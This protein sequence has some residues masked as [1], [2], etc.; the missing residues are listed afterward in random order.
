MMLCPHCGAK[1]DAPAP[2]GLT[3]VM[4]AALT[5]IRQFLAEHDH[6]PSYREIAARLGL[7]SPG[8]VHGIVRGLEHRGYVTI[9]PGRARSIMIINKGKAA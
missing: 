1:I 6:A 2:A 5:V 7:K 8:R 4:T 3:P 9:E